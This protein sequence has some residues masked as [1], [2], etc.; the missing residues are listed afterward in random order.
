MPVALPARITRRIASSLS[1]LVSPEAYS[2]ADCWRTAVACDLRSLV[3]ADAALVAVEGTGPA[4]FHAIDLDAGIIHDYQDH[5]ASVDAGITR[6][7]LHSIDVWCRRSL[8]NAA[9][10]QRSEYYNDFA[11]PNRLLDVFG[12]S[13]HAGSMRVRISLL[14]TRA[15]T[16]RGSATARLRLLELVHPAFRTGV[17]LSIATHEKT[18]RDSMTNIIDCIDHPLAL[19]DEAGRELHHNGALDRAAAEIDDEQLVSTIG[20]VTRAVALARK[21]TPSGGAVSVNVAMPNS[22]WRIRGSTLPWESTKSSSPIL[23]SLARTE[24]ACAPVTALRASYGL[25]AREAQVT[26]L[27]RRRRS[28]VEIARALG[29]SAHTARHHTENV[30]LKLRLQSRNQVEERLAADEQ[31]G[32]SAVAPSGAPGGRPR[33]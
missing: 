7:R 5:Y 12:I 3:G 24:V 27:L 4:A 32:Q 17:A 33:R 13:V 20:Q 15:S 22:E 11:R 8:W 14:C 30:L 6:Q 9:E 19:C 21:T 31:R 2:S 1:L 28:N 26:E 25:T 10:L 16:A 29:I 18:S 23:V